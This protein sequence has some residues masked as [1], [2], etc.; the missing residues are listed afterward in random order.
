M[1]ESLHHGTREDFFRFSEVLSALSFAL[2]IVEGQ[3]QGHVVRSSYIGMVLGERIGLDEEQRSA[4][5]YAL[6]LKDAGCSSNASRTS[7][8]FEADDFEVKRKFKTVDWDRLSESILYG[9]RAVSPQ[10]GLWHRI[11]RFLILGAEGQKASR[12]LMQIRCERGAE[13]TRLIGFPEE[14]AQAVRNLDEHWDGAG[15]PDGLEG[16]EIP[17]L[18][19]ICGLS[20]TAEVFYTEHGAAR[21]EEVVKARREKW[22]D[23]D[24]VDVFLTEARK[25]DIWEPLGSPDITQS[26]SRMEPADKTMLA[27]TERLDLVA[28]AFAEIIDAKSPFT[29]Q[30]SQGVANVAVAM[31]RRMGLQGGELRDQ[32]RAGLLHDIGKLGIS[33]RIMDKPGPLTDNEFARIKEHP[34][35]SRDI[36]CRVTPFSN[37]VERC[38]NHHEKLDGSGYPRGLKAEDLDLPT[39]ILTVADIFDALCKDRPYRPGMPLDRAL[40]ILDEESGD[41]L[42]PESVATLKD[43]IS[44]GEIR[45][46]NQSDQVSGGFS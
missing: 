36:L 38:A 41:K 30:H 42:C 3:P 21:A 27:T 26:L 43:L 18:A 25:G 19:R 4:L 14:T 1:T 40:A 37:I 46:D 39:R 11:R 44:D 9:A 33:S 13:I 2:D 34:K 22:F 8:L 28:R 31:S 32:M 16:E 24:L 45:T 12:H 20:Q 23:P 35:L 5:F 10:S 17:L 29:Y 6:L 7:A 15:H